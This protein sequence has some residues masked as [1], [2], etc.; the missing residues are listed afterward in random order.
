MDGRDKGGKMEKTYSNQASSKFVNIPVVYKWLGWEEY[1]E[2][3]FLS[4]KH[5]SFRA[6]TEAELWRWDEYI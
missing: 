2:C 5:T 6:N 4:H 3:F 1:H